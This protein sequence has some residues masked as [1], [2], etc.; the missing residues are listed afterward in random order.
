MHTTVKYRA[1]EAR[2]FVIL[3]FRRRKRPGQRSASE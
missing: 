1:R 2:A 3:D